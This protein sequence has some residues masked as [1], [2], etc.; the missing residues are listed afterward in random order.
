MRVRQIVWVEGEKTSVRKER[1]NEGEAEV[2]VKV[3]GT[4]EGGGKKT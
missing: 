4:T 1:I 3:S 2:G